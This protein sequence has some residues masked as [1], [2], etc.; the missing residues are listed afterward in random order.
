MPH[1]SSRTITT[2]GF[3]P[4]AW[5]GLSVCA[6]DPSDPRSIGH[7]ADAR[8]FGF[9]ALMLTTAGRGQVEIDFV[10]HACRPGTLTWIR[11]GQAFR[12]GTGAQEAAVLTFTAE[13]AGSPGGHAELAEGH[14]DLAA[15]HGDLAG[16]HGDL[17]SQTHWQLEGEDEDAVISEFTQLGVDSERLAPSPAAANLLRHQVAVLL[18][19]IA[20][21]SAQELATPEASTFAQ[22]RR[23]LEQSHPHSRRVEDY[24]Q[25]QGCS[26]RTLTRASLAITGRTAKQVVDDRVALEARRLLACTPMSVAE[27]GRYLGFGEP[28]NFGR[29]FQREVGTSP[30]HFRA[31]T[32][33]QH[34]SVLPAQRP[35]T[36]RA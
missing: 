35:S 15:N 8:Q 6:L 36:D 1:I 18:A 34:L 16:N 10:E 29:F 22:F 3:S 21:L 4:A 7:P 31:E 27:V 25:A 20:L 26:V 19:R 9:H 2:P 32:T 11:P 17:G 23:R 30:G 13:L 5:A 24:A 14:G 12:L 28:T 33:A